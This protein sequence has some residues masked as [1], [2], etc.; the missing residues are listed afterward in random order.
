MKHIAII[1]AKANSTRCPGKNMRSFL[2]QPLFL[3]SVLYAQAEGVA[4]IVSTDSDEVIAVCKE[5]NIRYVCEVVDDSTLANCIR[6]VLEKVHC[7][8]FA[9]LQPT[10]P[11]RVPGMLKNMLKALEQKTC[12]SAFTAQWMKH[13]GSYKG[14]FMRAYRDQDTKDPFMWFDGNIAV[15][16]RAYFEQ[17]GELFD[18]HSLPFENTFPCSLQ[19]DTE[20]EFFAI[21]QLAAHVSFN[22]FLPSAIRRVVIISNRHAFTRDYSVFVDHCDV[23]IRVNKMENL[24]DGLTGKKTDVAVVAACQPY[25]S[26][27]R[28]QRKVDVLKQ[29]PLIF[30]HPDPYE[31]LDKFCSEEDINNGITIPYDWQIATPYYTTLGKAIYIAEHTFPTAKLFFLGDTSMALRTCNINY[32]RHSTEQQYINT[33]ISSGKLISIL[34]ETKQQSPYIYSTEIQYDKK[35]YLFNKFLKW[36][37]KELQPETI[38]CRHKHWSDTLF[39]LDN[40]AR[41]KSLALCGTITYRTEKAFTIN[42]ND[43]S[44]DTFTLQPDGTYQSN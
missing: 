2:G 5:K 34:E 37:L 32:H 18:E 13:I 30:L 20:D 40:V 3:Y 15:T 36:Y 26:Y 44:T 24:D 11:L 28:A 35:I 33:L 7:D 39:I 29:V 25:L 41:R 9:L 23:V 12:E 17:S 16:S 38:Q 6:Q 8:I 21:Q 42:W 14:K 10:S 1:P 43:W 31:S 27:T 19:I 4:P 22:K